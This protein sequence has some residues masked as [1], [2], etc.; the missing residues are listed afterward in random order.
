MAGGGPEF[1]CDAML[2]GLAR[3]LRAAGYDAEFHY[4]IEDPALI[5]RALAT[6]AVLLSS[7][8]GLFELNV[9]KDRTVRA[10][11]VPRQPGKADQ[12]GFVLRRLRLPVRPDPRC[13]SCGGRLDEVEKADVRGRVP[14]RAFAA[15][16]RFWRCDRCGKL[17]WRGTHWRRIAATLAE[18][19]AAAGRDPEDT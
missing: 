18:V 8:A 10:V 15:R 7:D 5:R 16:D 6:G 2:G 13:M 12:L 3:W 9:V 17:L 14:P 1:V 4:G 19:G 11:F